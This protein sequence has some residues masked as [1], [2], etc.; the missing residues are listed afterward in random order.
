VDFTIRPVGES[1]WRAV[2]AV[3]NFFVVNSLAAYPDQPVSGDV[4]KEKHLAHPGYPFVVAEIDGEIAGFAY[5]APFHHASTMKKSATL[6]YFIDPEHTGK[7][8]GTRF[9]D[10]LMEGGRRLGITNF[11]AH[12][13]SANEGSIRFHARHGFVEC[14]RFLKIGAKAG[15]PFDMEWM[16]RID[17]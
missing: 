17:E 10:E 4:F 16:Q 2:T 15:Q 11:L 14:G 7:G 1:D 3:F 13:S 5:L 9:L 6:T 12:I 8:L